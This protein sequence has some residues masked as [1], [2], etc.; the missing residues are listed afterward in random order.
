MSKNDDEDEDD[1]GFADAQSVEPQLLLNH[2]VE[3]ESAAAEPPPTASAPEHRRLLDDDSRSA[4]AP[5]QSDDPEDP[6]QR[7]G[8]G[9][10]EPSLLSPPP[11]PMPPRSAGR[12]SEGSGG[13]IAFTTPSIKKNICEVAKRGAA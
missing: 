5:P 4:A 10:S 1:D 7:L 11:S 3:V 8:R 2:T 6:S 13:A 9:V 12:T